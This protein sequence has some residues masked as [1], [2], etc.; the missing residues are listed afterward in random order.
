MGI[1]LLIIGLASRKGALSIRKGALS[2][3]KE[4][5]SIRKGALSIHKGALSIHKG[6][7]SIFERSLAAA[8]PDAVP[9][10][11]LNDTLVEALTLFYP[12]SNSP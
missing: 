5:L 6:A 10:Q 12:P 11:R 9:L 8:T 7:L 3:R 2:I 4:A 1:F